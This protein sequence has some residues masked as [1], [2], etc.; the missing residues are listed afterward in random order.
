MEQ[1]R[2]L[3]HRYLNELILSVQAGEGIKL[4]TNNEFQIDSKDILIM[5]H[6]ERPEFLLSEMNPEDDL[7]SA[8]SLYRAYENLSPIEATDPRF[9]GYL[10][11]KDLYPYLTQRWPNVKIQKSEMNEKNYIF[12]HFLIKNS[13]QLLRNWLS[14]LWWS[15]Y[16]TIDTTNTND[17]YALTK[18]LFWNQT[19]RTRTLGAYLLARKKEIIL[20]FLEYCYEVGKNNFGNFEKEHQE[21]TEF[22]NLYGGSKPLVLLNRQEIK[23]LLYKNFKFD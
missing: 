20:G 19:L 15:V 22:L 10:S 23:T 16:L 1:Q 5:P 13:G 21:L 7:Q 3:R 18:V 8:I 9:W 4:F 6:V 17:E 2:I 11:L 12:E 14:G